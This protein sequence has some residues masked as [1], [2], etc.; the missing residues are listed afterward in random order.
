MKKLATQVAAISALALLGTTA[1]A[2]IIGASAGSE[3]IISFTNANGD[4][5]SFDSGDT[6]IQNGDFYALPSAVLSFI[7]AAGGAG[8][9]SMAIIAGNVNAR[10]YLTSSGNPVFAA[11]PDDGGVQIANAVRNLWAGQLT[12]FIQD[13][14]ASVPA[15][16]TSQ[17]D[18][19]GPFLT[20]TGSPNYLDGLF[21]S[22]GSGDFALTSLGAATD[23]LYLYN[24]AFGTGQLGFA[25]IAPRGA[26]LIANL[27]LA[28]AR[29]NV[30]V[31]PVP[32]AVWLFA[33]GLGLLGVARRKAF[34]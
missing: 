28:N 30:G 18:T 26:G 2:A 31:V 11:G 15:S 20:G 23:P 33:S 17:N 6:N 13:L 14:N 24:V 29:V 19:Y 16:P 22:W 1:Q 27:D 8:S 34:T 7:N 4:S 5:I 9:V 25:S 3:A 12:Q 10:N 32:A 21:D